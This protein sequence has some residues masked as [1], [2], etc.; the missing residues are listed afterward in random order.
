MNLQTGASRSPFKFGSSLTLQKH[1]KVKKRCYTFCVLQCVKC[2]M[3]GPFRIK[4]YEPIFKKF[5]IKIENYL[6]SEGIPS[7]K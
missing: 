7:L 1:I 6:N 3:H 2:R 4:K 5:H